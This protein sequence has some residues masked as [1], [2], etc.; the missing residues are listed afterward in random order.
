[1][2]I[3]YPDIEQ[4]IAG[5]RAPS[6]G[7]LAEMEALA[8]REGFPIIGPEVGALLGILARASGA[9]RVLELGSGF[10]YSAHWFG[11]ALPHGGELICTDGSSTNRDLALDFLQRGG[12]LE[13]VALTYLVG[14]AR[15]LLAL[16]K[17][18]LDIVFCDID[19]EGYPEVVAPVASLLRPGG[20]FITDNT[21]WKGLVCGEEPADETTEAVRRFNRLV[22]SH[23][24]LSSVILPLRDGVTVAIKAE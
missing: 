8:A 13:R 3:V 1:V 15:D 21:L 14:D 12:L 6:A 4:Y 18:P 11:A 23:P 16:Q 17:G 10:G 22:A 9:R 24:D 2:G 19:K 5:L 7:V 20:L